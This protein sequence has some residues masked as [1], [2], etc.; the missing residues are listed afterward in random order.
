MPDN[1]R[2]RNNL[3]VPTDKHFFA[4]EHHVDKYYLHQ[5]LN[6]LNVGCKAL[7]NSLTKVKSMQHSCMPVYALASPPL[8]AL[9]YNNTRR[10]ISHISLRPQDYRKL[11][12]T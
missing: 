10:H 7:R 5:S 11:G 1:S 3:K 4:E 2:Q 6:P 12:K 8:G 9:Y